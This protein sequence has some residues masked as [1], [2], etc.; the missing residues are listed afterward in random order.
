M[1]EYGERSTISDEC[2]FYL[3]FS[4]GLLIQIVYATYTS[5][6]TGKC[7][8]PFVDKNW[9]LFSGDSIGSPRQQLTRIFASPLDIINFDIA[10][11][12]VSSGRC[13]FLCI[14]KWK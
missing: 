4:N 6:G 8:I 5:S 12:G 9:V 11:Y 3:K 1:I 7:I 13:V 10:T 14:G 2:E